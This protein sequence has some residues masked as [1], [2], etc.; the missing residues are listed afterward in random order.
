MPICFFALPPCKVYNRNLRLKKP[1]VCA[2]IAGAVGDAIMGIGNA[3]NIGFANNG[4][5][6][7]M[8][9]WGEGISFSR[10]L[11]YL[12]GIAV[13][14]FGGAVL[15]YVV[16]FEDETERPAKTAQKQVEAVDKM[17]DANDI[18]TGDVTIGAP[19]SGQVIPLAEVDDEVFASGV[20]GPGVG[21][22][23]NKGEV[24]APEDCIVALVYDTKH[25]IGLKLKDDVELL[26]HVG[27]NT[28]ELAGK[29]FESFVENGAVVKKGTK[30]VAFDL[31]K[32]KEAGYDPTVCVLVAN[33]T[34]Y[35]K[36]NT[37]A[38]G[39]ADVSRDVISVEK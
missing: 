21:I 16:G 30:L 37:V 19:V 28:V 39:R 38:G 20:L 7:I 24:V 8:S 17:A 11:S 35:G 18:V 3:V 32:I 12:I 9:Y 29:Y 36:V 14:F 4:I 22:I 5:L 27:I 23:P 10:F 13:A 33:G 15:T 2:V 25:A 1:M 34:N 26:I 6:T 31:E